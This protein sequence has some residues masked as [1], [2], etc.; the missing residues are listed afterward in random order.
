ME[1]ILLCGIHPGLHPSPAPALQ[2]DLPKEDS[3]YECGL[4]SQTVGF[5]FLLCYFPGLTSW[6]A[7]LYGLI[8]AFL[9]QAPCWA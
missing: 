4:W 1:F 6:V 5:K 8:G 2:S 3:D 9:K 7:D